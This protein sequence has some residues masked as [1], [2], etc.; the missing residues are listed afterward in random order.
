MTQVSVNRNCPA[1][2]FS[3]VLKD[4]T[5]PPLNQTRDPGGRELVFIIQFIP[6]KNNV[7][8]VG[9]LILLFRNN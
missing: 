4:V 7:T 3:P 6:E 1:S 2:Y 5:I 8:Y 9:S